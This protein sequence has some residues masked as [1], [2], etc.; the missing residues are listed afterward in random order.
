M[1]SEDD[2]GDP[3]D[4]KQQPKPKESVVNYDPREKATASSRLTSGKMLTPDKNGNYVVTYSFNAEFYKGGDIRW[5]SLKPHSSSDDISSKQFRAFKD[6]EKYIP[7]KFLKFEDDWHKRSDLTYKYQ[8]KLEEEFIRRTGKFLSSDK[9]KEFYTLAAAQADLEMEKPSLVIGEVAQFV[10]QKS[11]DSEGQGYAPFPENGVAQRPIIYNSNTDFINILHET[12]HHLGLM[13]P[14]HSVVSIPLGHPD[15]NIKAPKIFEEAKIGTHITPTVM[16]WNTTE[17]VEHGY[18]K[19]GVYDIYETSAHK[20]IQPNTLLPWDIARLQDV[21]GKNLQHNAGN[22]THKLSSKDQG[23]Q[24]IWDASGKD[25]LDASG[26]K[27]GVKINLWEGVHSYSQ[28]GTNITFLAYGSNIENAIGGDGDDMIIGNNMDNTFT[29]KGGDNT[30]DLRT[31]D[32]G[33]FGHDTITDFYTHIFDY[34]AN[35]DKIIVGD[36]IEKVTIYKSGKDALILFQDKYGR[37]I[38]DS[39][40]TLK[41]FDFDDVD[42]IDF[43]HSDKNGKQTEISSKNIKISKDKPPLLASLTDGSESK[44]DALAGAAKDKFNTAG[45]PLE[46][47]SDDKALAITVTSKN[48]FT[49]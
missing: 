41:N 47:N 45:K 18:Y 30:F 2:T 21:Y 13:H 29:G 44:L 33:S 17:I 8:N 49:A 28:A 10:N 26:E 19:D 48:N 27:D 24:T 11:E 43:F 42:D 39:S 15:L 38:P 31:P 37:T 9:R 36:E 25:I 23:A 5:Q 35:E 6:Y 7:V 12:G 4:P 14:F 46:E 34:L 3:K 40:L 16:I 20:H 22:T 32:G 1:A